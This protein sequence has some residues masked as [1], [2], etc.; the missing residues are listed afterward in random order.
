V[1]SNAHQLN[2]ALAA[3]DR[4]LTVRA[5]S[6]VRLSGKRWS[7]KVLPVELPIAPIRIGIVTLK[8]RTISPAAR[9]FIECAR[10]VAKPFAKR[11]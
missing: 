1:T 6:Y 9:L 3:T 5:A 4:F 7:V 2:T 10:K 11:S 8:G